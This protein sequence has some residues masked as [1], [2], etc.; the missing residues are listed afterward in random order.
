LR[1]VEANYYSA[2]VAGGAGKGLPRPGSGTP[3][4]NDAGQQIGEKLPNGTTKVF[5]E[6]MVGG[7]KQKAD[8]AT[9]DLEATTAKYG[10][11]TG[12]LGNID[13]N[14]LQL[15]DKSGEVIQ[16]TVHAAPTGI[17][18]WF[19]RV[20][21]QSTVEKQQAPEDLT[22]GATHIQG[23]TND[24]KSFKLPM[25]AFRQVVNLKRD[26]DKATA[27]AAA[28]PD[29]AATQS[30]SGNIPEVSSQDE[31]MKYPAG[32][33]VKR[34]GTNQYYRVPAAPNAT[35][36]NFAG[37]G[38]VGPNPRARVIGRVHPIYGMQQGAIVPGAPTQGDSVMAAL[39]PGEMVLNQPQQKAVR[40][41]KGK[42]H[43][44]TP[45]QRAAFARA[46]NG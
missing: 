3:V 45:D 10:L 19:K 18:P 14:S 6:W 42:E 2:G 37:G 46:K 29:R 15:L 34:K 40:P 35:P 11:N 31:A 32:S 16:P 1:N 33:V 41:I 43:K 39:T 20:T 12:D 25:D 44:L 30:G 7:V 28:V 13:E 21:G 8:K 4:Y 5:P 22:A 27:A 17:V 38:V 23:Q 26:A 24:G 36:A 9:K